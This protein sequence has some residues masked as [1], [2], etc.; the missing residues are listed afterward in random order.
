M[1]PATTQRVLVVLLAVASVGVTALITLNVFRNSGSR[2][3]GGHAGPQPPV[4]AELPDFT[5]TE[6]SGD[7]VGLADLRG[8][9][10]VVGFIFTKCAGA[11]PA[12]TSR[13]A[14]LQI[15][16]SDRP[17]WDDIR[18]VSI[19]VDPENDTPEV[20]R[21]YARLAHAD[22]ERWLMLTG[23]RDK[24][25]SLVTQGFKLGVADN[26]DNED[27]P[28]LHSQKLVLVDRAGRIRGYYDA[29]ERKTPDGTVTP[30]ERD[31][32]LADLERVLNE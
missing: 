10:S 20:L 14:E 28:I 32:L 25:W 23:Q 9:V 15:K 22:D 3:H 4:L 6:R 13:M 19:S 30:D 26:P 31:A 27:V 8:Q 11:C 24:V 12:L 5:L 18:L 29:L 17:D 2:P 7:A 21:E 1:N 16:L